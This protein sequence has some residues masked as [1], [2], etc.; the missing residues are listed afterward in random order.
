METTTTEEK[1]FNYAGFGKRM[2]AMLIDRVI[3]SLAITVVHWEVGRELLRMI[4]KNERLFSKLYK[5]SYDTIDLSKYDVADSLTYTAVSIIMV[6]VLWCYYAGME[7]SPWKGT[8]GKRLMGLEVTDEQ[9]ERISFAKASGR[10][11]A[12]IISIVVLCFGYLAM[13]FNNTKQ[14]WHDKLSGCIVTEK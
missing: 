1:H 13:L 5:K 3:I 12:K 2:A 8:L 10:Y 7:S 9:G 4:K 6:F 11:F 14:T